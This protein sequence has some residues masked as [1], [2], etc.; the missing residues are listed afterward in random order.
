MSQEVVSGDRREV[1][2]GRDSDVEKHCQNIRK[3]FVG[4]PLLC[5]HVAKTIVAIRRGIEVEK[6]VD[7][8]F[9]VIDSN[10]GLL[11]KHLSTR[12]LIAI[13]DTIAD[14]GTP[15]QRAASLSIIVLVNTTKLSETERILEQRNLAK[16]GHVAQED[17][18]KYFSNWPHEL[19]DGV[20][21]YHLGRGDMPRNMFARLESNLAQTPRVARLF[22][23]IRWRL[24]S[25]ENLYSRMSKLNSQFWRQSDVA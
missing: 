20:T 1:V 8:F 11:C 23:T 13:C 5:F 21:S 2:V 6:N 15:I 16:T 25:G 9:S 18:A 4:L 7:E 12:W 22:A 3:E 17:Q 24:E 14:H 10:L 19:W